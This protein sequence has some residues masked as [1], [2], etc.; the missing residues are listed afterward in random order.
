[1]KP[2]AEPEQKLE[3]IHV[4]GEGV[5]AHLLDLP[6][7]YITINTP[8]CCRLTLPGQLITLIF[9]DV[10][11]VFYMA[12]TGVQKYYYPNNSPVSDSDQQW[13]NFLGGWLPGRKRKTE[14]YIR[15]QLADPNINK[16][17]E[18]LS[19]ELLRRGML[20]GTEFRAILETP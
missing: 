6:V 5:F 20:S 17:I 15:R 7:K 14:V 16:Q 8:A 13:I 12:G 19:A 9:R 2:F 11:C 4:A 10:G 18:K 3:A 1:M